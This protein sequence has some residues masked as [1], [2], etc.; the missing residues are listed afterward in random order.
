[1]SAKQLTPRFHRGRL[2]WSRVD[3]VLVGDYHT[4]IILHIAV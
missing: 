2:F 1:V 4:A 3:P